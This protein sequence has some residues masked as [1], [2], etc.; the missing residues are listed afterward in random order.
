M[1]KL[2]ESRFYTKAPA[3]NTAM[4]QPVFSAN[5]LKRKDP[6]DG[7]LPFDF[8]HIVRIWD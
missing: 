3:A 1:G 6:R 8:H 4:E 5:D 2:P 7:A